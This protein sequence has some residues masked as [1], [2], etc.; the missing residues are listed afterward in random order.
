[1]VVISSIVICR[2][3]HL[4]QARLDVLGRVGDASSNF[5]LPLP[6]PGVPKLPNH[7]DIRAIIVNAAI[8]T[9]IGFVESIAAK[10]FARRHDYFVSVNCELVTLGIVNIFG[11]F[12]Q[13]FPAFGSVSNISGLVVEIRRDLRG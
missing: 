8:I 4:D 7:A 9:I 1:M 10:S 5:N 6:F 12:F 13:A 3:F 2:L 11:G